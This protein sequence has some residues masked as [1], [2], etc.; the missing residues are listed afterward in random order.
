MEKSRKPT[1][2]D[3]RREMMLLGLKR[4]LAQDDLSEAEK[5]AIE[6]EVKKLEADMQ[7]A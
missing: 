1:C 7:M 3:Y 2:N 5:Q 6:V 4:R